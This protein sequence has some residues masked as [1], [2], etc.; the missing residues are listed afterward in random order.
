MA[1]VVIGALLVIAGVAL[2]AGRTAA[3]GRLSQADARSAAG[4]A[5]LEPTGKGRRLSVK[6][7]FLGI[8]MAAAGAI[9][10]FVG[11]LS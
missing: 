1:L 8:G 5:T 10:I 9:L 3:R 2:A 7:D 11:A 4:P 6:A